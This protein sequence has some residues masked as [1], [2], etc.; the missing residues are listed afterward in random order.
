MLSAT[1]RRRYSRENGLRDV[2]L[3]FAGPRT[4]RSSSASERP[5]RD[6]EGSKT[7]MRAPVHGSSP[8]TYRKVR[9]GDANPSSESATLDQQG[10]SAVLG[11]DAIDCS[12]YCP[13]A[14]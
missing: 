12:R 8:T 10:W 6:A 13:E 4:L 14:H 9:S 5:G 2:V 7:G 3:G 11:Y 1:C